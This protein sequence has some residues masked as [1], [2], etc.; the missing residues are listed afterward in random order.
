MR[1]CVVVPAFDA[2][3]TIGEVVEDATARLPACPVLVIDDG[4]RDATADIARSRR[5][6]VLR[7]E[8]KGA[9]IATGLAEAQRRGFD[10]VVT[11][12]ADG[13]HPASSALRVLGGS[14][15]LRALVL[16][17]RDLVRDGAPRANRFGNDVSNFFL[18]HFAGR[19]LRDTQCGLRRY[20]VRETLALGVRAEGYAF[21]AEVVLRA[22]AVGL[23]LVEVPVEV[24]YPPA[25][26][27]ITHFRSVRDP[28]RIVANVV[29]TLV[30]LRLRGR[31]RG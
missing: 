22:L 30:D 15:D 11:M 18:S 21:E 4:S 3:S 19:P 16:G 25:S 10:V 31:V 7:H 1:A 28:V 6:V 13:Q 12:D 24:V 9:A 20:P 27:R 5:A 23:P 2:A 29:R 26:R 14:D 8:R 17:T